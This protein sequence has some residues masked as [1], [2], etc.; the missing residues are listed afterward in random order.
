MAPLPG[1]L[2][3]FYVAP[4][5]TVWASDGSGGDAWAGVVV[6]LPSDQLGV[7]P[8]QRSSDKATEMVFWERLRPRVAFAK[9]AG[10]AP[11]PAPA[12][13]QAYATTKSS[14]NKKGG[15]AAQKGKAA[16]KS[17]SKASNTASATSQPSSLAPTT[18]PVDALMQ[19]LAV[20]GASTL[21]ELGIDPAALAAAHAGAAAKLR[22]WLKMSLRSAKNSAAAAGAMS[23]RAS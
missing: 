9:A 17:K 22:P 14:E 12:P 16:A 23:A 7:W 4:G 6:G 1:E 13:A 11:T 10:P 2:E 21:S 5:V 8:V 15:S 20:A 3:A 19:I 18:E